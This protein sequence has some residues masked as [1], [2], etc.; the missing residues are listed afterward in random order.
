[1]AEGGESAIDVFGKVLTKLSK[2]LGREPPFTIV[3]AEL[4]AKG[5]IADGQLS[6]VKRQGLTNDQRG[7]EVA[8]K[9]KEKIGDSD[10]PNECV[11]KICDVFE[12][13]TVDYPTLKGYGAKMRKSI[14]NQSRQTSGVNKTKK[15][16]PKKFAVDDETDGPQASK[17]GHK[18]E[19]ESD[20][21]Q[22]SS[23][24]DEPMTKDSKNPTGPQDMS[25]Q[26]PKQGAGNKKFDKQE[27]PP[28]WLYEQM[29]LDRKLPKPETIETED[30]KGIE[31]LLLPAT[32][33]EN[34]AVEYYLK[35][36]SLNCS[37]SIKAIDIDGLIIYV[38]SYGKTKV[39]VTMTA[40]A[41]N[42]QGPVHAAVITTKILERFTSIKYVVAIGVCFGKGP[43][44]DQKLGDVVVSDEIFNFVSKRRGV[45]DDSQRGGNHTLRH[46]TVN[47]FKKLKMPRKIKVLQGGI[48]STADLIDNPGIKEELFKKFP[49]AIAGEMEGIGVV[50]AIEYTLQRVDVIVIKGIGDW[51]DG[52]K[53]ATKGW[54][55]FAA[56]AAAH[57]V[58]NVL[59]Q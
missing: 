10:N 46:D 8:E 13:D 55:P 9:L 3:T 41:K 17:Q 30:L 33:T 36:S 18:N 15:C 21:E 26:I 38:G 25:T 43:S 37:T 35:L 32:V 20:D 47:I 16:P 53:E 28:M 54:K 23:D 44:K 49:N 2:I 24:E 1:M 14:S 22:E 39:M 57:Y 29:I 5:L 48:V 27:G 50:T 4:N 56:R 31:Y 11:L 19:Q 59:N 58:H 34:D 51:G 12:S 40:P 45:D 7:N 42:K 6:A 52:N